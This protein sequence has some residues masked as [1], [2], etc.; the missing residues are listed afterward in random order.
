MA[1]IAVEAFLL[2]R[3][4]IRI[5]GHDLTGLDGVKAQEL[6]SYLLLHRDRAHSREML[7]G[8][9][10]GERPTEMARKHLRQ[11]L[12]QV[13]S[14][15]QAKAAGF[16]KL[17]QVDSDYVSLISSDDLWLDVSILE[18]AFTRVHGIAGKDL[19]LE[20]LALVRDVVVI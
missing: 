19:G 2:G 15:L 5:A 1:T 4:R 10:W 6:L 13:H 16:G 8:L 20:T 9:L 18:N 7:S 11:T 12:W 3:F 14:A 17:L